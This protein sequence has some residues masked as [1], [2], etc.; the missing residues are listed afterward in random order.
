M[1]KIF[2]FFREVKK[3]SFLQ[4]F[5]PQGR[6]SKNVRALGKILANFWPKFDKNRNFQKIKW[7]YFVGSTFSFFCSADFG[8][9]FVKICLI[10]QRKS[11]PSGPGRPSPSRPPPKFSG[12]PAP[13]RFNGK[14]RMVKSQFFVFFY[15]PTSSSVKKSEKQKRKISK[16]TEN[17]YLS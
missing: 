5:A 2:G 17:F 8:R 13:A 1:S 4:N 11:E 12:G 7:F 10:F 3:G 6:M 16:K 14:D 15:Q 9:N